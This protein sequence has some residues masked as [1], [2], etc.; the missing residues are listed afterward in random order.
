MSASLFLDLQYLGLDGVLRD[1][2]EH[3]HCL[4]LSHPM[5]TVHR[6]CLDRALPPR[7]AEEHVA[8]RGKVQTHSP[9]LERDQHH[10]RTIIRVRFSD[11]HL[12]PCDH[13]LPPFGRH[14]PIKAAE[15]DS[16][17][18]KDSSDAVEEAR[19]LREHERLVPAVECLEVTHKLRYLG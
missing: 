8:R 19:K 13:R 15:L 5:H 4:A 12:E 1:E 10:D 16:L 9:G 7:V 11:G 6:L 3:A 18:L 14:A 17:L 2:L